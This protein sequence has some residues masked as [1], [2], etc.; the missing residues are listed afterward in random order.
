M[1]L[2]LTPVCCALV[3]FVMAPKLSLWVRSVPPAVLPLLAMMAAIPLVCGLTLS[4]FDPIC[5]AATLLTLMGSVALLRGLALARKEVVDVT[6][7]AS[8]VDAAL[9][10]S[11]YKDALFGAAA[12]V[13]LDGEIV[14]VV[15]VP[16]ACV[17]VPDLKG[18]SSR[19]GVSLSADRVCSPVGSMHYS[20]TWN[21]P[22]AIACAFCFQSLL[23]A[24]LAACFFVPGLLFK[25]M[26]KDG[27]KK[28]KISSSFLPGHDLPQASCLIRV[29]GRSALAC[30]ELEEGHESFN[31]NIPWDD[32]SDAVVTES[33]EYPCAA[34]A[35]EG[36]S[37][38]VH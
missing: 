18:N 27:C 17:L 7:A 35:L 12:P 3:K 28:R 30:A 21:L 32:V 22:A 37:S 38:F 1:R 25:G 29:E 24:M 13:A 6:G 33:P 11:A 23:A 10:E 34:A 16:S 15:A 4:G 14:G 31:K 20:G 5:F 8:E 2:F 9:C 36:T 19:V 26:E